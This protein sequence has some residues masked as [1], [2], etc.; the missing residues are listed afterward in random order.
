MTHRR[1]TFSRRSL[2]ETDS[3]T[4]IKAEVDAIASDLAT[5][6]GLSEAARESA[7]EV[8]QVLDRFETVSR[9]A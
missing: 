2:T 3:L 4:A 7:A 5:L 9:L 1:V 6:E 8:N